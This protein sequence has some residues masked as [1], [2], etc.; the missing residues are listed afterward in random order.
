VRGA[1]G[2]FRVRSGRREELFFATGGAFELRDVPA[3][4][5][6]VEVTAA[7]VAG[8]AELTL[9]PGEMRTVDLA[10][11]PPAETAVEEDDDDDDDDE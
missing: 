10:L 6:V 2:A 7:G 8:R 11:A 9:A 5:T 1:P 4:E 3:G